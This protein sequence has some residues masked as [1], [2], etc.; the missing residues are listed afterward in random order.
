M[1][2]MNN[3]DKEITPKAPRLPIAAPNEFP[4]LLPMT[5]WGS[6][7]QYFSRSHKTIS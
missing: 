1:E 5:H 2:K 3:K 4:L 6:G 7:L